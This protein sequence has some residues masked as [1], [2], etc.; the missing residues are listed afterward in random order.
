MA[1]SMASGSGVPAAPAGPIVP[2]NPG[3]STAHGTRR[4]V[5]ILGGV[6]LTLAAVGLIV[7]L[8]TGRS[9]ATY[10]AGSPEAAFQGYLAAWQAGDLE[11]A[12]AHLSPRVRALA[13][14]DE[15]RAMDRDY[16]WGRDED[17]RVVLTAARI[18]GDRAR[19]DLRVESHGT[20]GLFGG[21]DTWSENRS[22]TLVRDGNEWYVDEYLAGIDPV[23]IEK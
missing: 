6:I 10:P 4:T 3:V 16:G 9:A 18:T 2:A 22:V 12:Y 7:V 23:W 15:Y 13:T 19:L 5:L 1:G 14:V 17:R 21:A 20:G 8:L 11:G